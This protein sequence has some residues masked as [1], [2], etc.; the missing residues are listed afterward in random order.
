MSPAVRAVTVVRA[1]PD[2]AHRAPVVRI[3]RA[4]RDE[5]RPELLRVSFARVDRGGA[6]QE[7]D[8]RHDD[9]SC[10]RDAPAHDGLR[11]MP[12]CRHAA[13]APDPPRAFYL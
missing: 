7:R 8:H 13:K 12:R 3:E 5:D 2:G 6:E 1:N 11:G 9:E 10:G 4:V